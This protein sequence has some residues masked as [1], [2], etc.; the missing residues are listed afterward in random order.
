MFHKKPGQAETCPFAQEG[1]FTALQ[2]SF[3]FLVQQIR[4]CLILQRT[5]T[6]ELGTGLGDATWFFFPLYVQLTLIC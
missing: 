5:K 4:Q 3:F 6:P 1:T 2:V